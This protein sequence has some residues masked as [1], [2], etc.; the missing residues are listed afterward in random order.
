LIAGLFYY[1][2]KCTTNVKIMEVYRGLS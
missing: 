2:G 1:R